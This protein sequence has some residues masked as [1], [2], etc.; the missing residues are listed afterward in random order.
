MKRRLLVGCL[1]CVLAGCISRVPLDVADSS[2]ASTE[3]NP[4]AAS[5]GR[6]AEAAADEPKPRDVA[7]REAPA[8]DEPTEII[9]FDDL[10]LG[11]GADVRFR[12]FMLSDRRAERLVGKRVNLAGYMGPPDRL[13]GVTDFILLRNLECKFGPGGQADHL[14]HVLM[15]DG[16]SVDFTDKVVY[17]EG[18]LKLNPF[19]AP[20][21]ATTWSIYDLEG[22][23]V[24]TSA[25][26]RQR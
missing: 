7:P 18:T 12:P 8:A 2:G 20:D 9:T 10:I 11:M 25:P 4:S 19:H 3:E 23:N 22:T 26:R 24:S 15:Q 1:L 6:N 16:A 5:P 17:V 13:Q 14:V 21:G